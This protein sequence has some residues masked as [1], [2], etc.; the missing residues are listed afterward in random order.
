MTTVR[1]HAE[2][3]GP[4]GNLAAGTIGGPCCS[5]YVLAYGGAFSGGAD[6]RTYPTPT[7]HDIASAVVP[8][9]N[10]LDSRMQG[11]IHAWLQPHEVLVPP[12]CH[13]TTSSSAEP[14]AEADHVTVTVG[15]TC[16]A[17]A[18]SESEL[19]QEATARLGAL[20]THQVGP[21][22]RLV[23]DVRTTLSGTT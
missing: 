6:A 14:G 3:T 15:E 8:L 5:A 13:T 22:Y 19:Q 1:A 2:D 7:A 18:Y 16:A 17:A 9:R 23:N 21:S 11:A 20:A 12:T 4:A 10:Q